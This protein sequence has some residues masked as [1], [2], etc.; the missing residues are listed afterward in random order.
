MKRKLKCYPVNSEDIHH[1]VPGDGL[2]LKL[3]SLLGEAQYKMTFI[4]ERKLTRN[5]SSSLAFLRASLLCFITLKAMTV[6]KE[7]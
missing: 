6:Y 2:I 7:E 3:I 1:V 5:I 4:S